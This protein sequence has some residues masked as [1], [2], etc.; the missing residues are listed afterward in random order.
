M[1]DPTPP[2]DFEALRAALV[3]RS[4]RLS[5]RLSQVAQFF[6]NHPEEVAVST[7]VR[8]ADLAAVPPA[9]ITRFAKELGFQGFSDLQLVFRERLLGPRLPYAERVAGAGDS[10][11]DQPGT[12]FGSFIQAAVQ[13]L[14]RIEEALDRDQLAACVELLA[15]TDVVHVAAARGAFGLG[16]YMVYGL[17]SIGRRA[18]LI[19]NIGAMR[20]MQVAAMGP[21]DTLLAM[22]FD[23]YTPETVEVVR[24]AAARGHPVLVITDNALSPVVSL[25]THVLY[26]N[27]ARLGHFRSQIPALVVAQAMIVG[28]GRRLG[29]VETVQNRKNE[30]SVALTRRLAKDGRGR[31]S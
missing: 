30:N 2:R 3:A 28:L 21:G 9:T 8:L 4:D 18:Q 1:T 7:L 15:T 11:L 5:K 10:D 16:A 25:A 17:G 31:T 29:S 6:L 23:D 20:G 12:V 14:L 26:V 22:T 13:S 24:L 27:E 19:D